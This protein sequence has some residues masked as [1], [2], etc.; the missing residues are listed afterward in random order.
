M[1]KQKF[2]QVWMLA[3]VPKEYGIPRRDV[4]I[5]LVA[6]DRVTDQLVG[7][8]CKYYAPGTK[9]YKGMIDSF[10]NEI[11]KA[12][13]SNGIIVTT[14]S[15]W[16]R[17]AEEA[18]KYR[19]K[20]I[21]RIG[22]DDL[23]RSQ[24]DWTT[25]TP[26]SDQEKV[27]LKD[28]KYPL[29]HQRPAI[30][31]VLAGFKEGDRGK[32]I[33]APGTGKT[34]T[35]LVIAEELAKEKEGQFRVLY[36]VPSIQLLSQSLRGWT[37]DATATMDTI[38][39]CS[40]RKVTKKESE[41]D[42]FDISIADIGFPATTDSDR[43]LTYQNKLSEKN[44]A[45]E[46]LVVFST[47]HSIDVI[48]QAQVRGFYDFD[49]IICDEAHRTTGSTKMGE[50]G[51]FFVQVHD[52]NKVK[53]S[54][55]LYQTAT[56][57]VY[58]DNA[59]AKANDLSVVIAD[60]SDETL[61][62]KE[63]FRLGFGE[64]V[65]RGVLS[66]Y[67]VVVLSVSET[68]IQREMQQVLAR[69]NSELEF[70]DVTKIIGCWNGL[71]KR[72]SFSNNLYGKPMKRAIAFTNTIANS[73][74]IT[75][76]FQI[77]V[78]EYLGQDNPNAFQVEIQHADGS[79][80]ALKKN[81]KINWLK[82]SVPDKTCRILSNAKFLT[83][84]VDIPDLDAVLFLQ[85]RKSK[86]DI[87]QAVGRVMRKSSDKDYG[88]VILPIG[89]P[90]GNEAHK[91]L[92]N[93]DKYRAVWDVLNAL[94]SIDERFDATVNKLE[95]NK[96]K[97]SQINVIGIGNHPTPDEET[98]EYQ[99]TNKNEQTEILLSED[100][101]NIEQN[102]YGK[103]VEK[104]GN[105]RY[106]ETWS[107]DVTEIAQQHI[108]RITSLVNNEAEPKKEFN[109][110]LKG[111]HSNINDSITKEEAIEMVAQ[112]LITKPVFESLFEQE[113]FALNN[114]ISRSMNNIV[115]SLENYGFN[116]DLDQLQGFYESVQ[117]RAEDIDNLQ[118]KQDIIK[119]L[120]E[121]FF[122]IGFPNITQKLGIVFTPTPI[123]DFIIKFVES[124]LNKHLNKSMN[125]PNVNILDP[126]TGTG[127]FIA[128]LLQSEIISK[129]N[130]LYKYT[131]E[132][133]ANE[134]IL[135]SYYIAAIN[136][137]ET[138]K[139]IYKSSEYHPFEGVVLTDTFKDKT[140][141][142][143][144]DG[145][146]FADN[147]MRRR[148]QNESPITVI[149]GNPPYSGRQRS[150]NDDNENASYKLLEERIENTYV[151]YSNAKASHSVYDSY[152]KA[153]RWASDKLSDRGVI[154][155]VTQ[156]S[157]ID[158]RSLDGLRKCL[159]DDFNHIY[160]VNI[161]GAIRAKSQKD[162]DQFEGGNV[163]DIKTGIAIVILV[164]D[165]TKTNQIYYY[166]IG[167]GL[168]K[169]EKLNILNSYDDPLEEIQFERVDVDLHNDWINHK[170]EKYQELTP[171]WDTNKDSIFNFKQLGI[172]S[173][174]DSWV[175]NFSLD[176][177][178]LNVQKTI[179]EYNNNVDIGNRSMDSKRIS[180]SDE[181][182]RL[183]NKKQ[184][185][186]FSPKEIVTVLYRPFTKKYLYL[187][188]GLVARPG[189]WKENFS[190]E[191][192]SLLLPGKSNRRAFSVLISNFIPDQ[193]IMDA[194]TH[195]YM[196]YI[197]NDG[198]MPVT[199]NIHQDVI[200]RLGIDESQV[201]D[202]LYGIL[203][204]KEY[205]SK[206]EN[207][208]QKD[209]ARIPKVRNKDAFIDA[210]RQLRDLHINY[211][212]IPPLSSIKINRRSPQPS[213]SVEKMKFSKQLVDGRRVN[214]KSIIIFN[215]DIKIENIPEQAYEYEINGRSAIEWIMDSYRVKVDRLSG[216]IDNPNDYSDDSKYIYNLLLSVIN[217]SVQ[218]I[219][220]VTKLPPLDI[221]ED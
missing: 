70:D 200:K 134:I 16:S 26:A 192:L 53:G 109:I 144:I 158:N 137:E 72:K 18:L 1:F 12:Y 10:L 57:R 94:R 214:D 77:V 89:V 49:L 150:E 219:E 11:G 69:N 176:K 93:N 67:K 183:F 100:L 164:K 15:E 2:S 203:H 191:N 140:N 148:K 73:K 17:D 125:D 62:G 60:M 157:Y 78:D 74:L 209:Y 13:Y 187:D 31:S 133:Y 167:N 87:A 66:D 123:V 3:D 92:D 21:V 102:I 193:N 23:L 104:V 131:N 208:F 172:N 97:P 83:E 110:F 207:N 174:R 160:V 151:R 198:F 155:F 119:Q 41:K 194:G 216:I 145:V 122:Q 55:R 188:R 146:F 132:I 25:Y 165:E 152:I 85:P 161:K 80:N 105:T 169:N 27:Q 96:K 101:K 159:H 81:Q 4:G 196:K 210:G 64:A 35:S 179:N 107:K 20:E 42:E 130:L 213:Y 139:E 54:K 143:Q 116:K 185:L 204:S 168:T 98:G 126:F 7:I 71:L 212:M 36:L 59:K 124:V 117:L 68:M 182:I 128:R 88:Y 90:T 44:E 189:S 84:G 135:L 22:A 82:S 173:K 8:Q 38:A 39:V 112:H 147:S 170:D 178:K 47:Y 127:T 99:V 33:M 181:L 177:L 51:S 76:A 184:K 29:P 106:W 218:T 52:N 142:T 205:I 217:V 34:Y 6:K 86:I 48:T 115:Q 138:F 56:P 5:D 162:I 154:G 79:M 166:D 163:F 121:K 50:D 120:Y 221:I 61:Y 195:G 9:I 171:L 103:I 220:I 14:S 111:L 37:G 153:L 175:T 28:R 45:A 75:E 58:G 46:L 141:Q 63:F 180:W 30:E 95:L 197:C 65:H 114:P 118:A 156:N 206:Y 136:I 43:L 129:E 108:I 91:V 24:I 40:D 199:S 186:S 149:I 202:Y 215:S 211:E 190:V 113:S 19:S 32:L 201:F